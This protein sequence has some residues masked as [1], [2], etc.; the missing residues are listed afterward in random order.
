MPNKFES[1]AGWAP[2]GSQFQS[3]G[4]AGN[5]VGGVLFG[6]LLTPIGIAFAAKGGADIRYWVIVGAVTDRWTAA[7]EIIG[8]SLILLLVVV[9]AAFSP[10]G[11]AV[12]GLVWGI[13]PGIL[14]LLFPDETFALIANLTF[15]NSEMQVALHAWVTYGFALVSGFMLLGAGIVGTLRRR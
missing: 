3:R 13:L 10:I 11:T 14:H 2:P 1:P 6:L 9:A 8:G 7:L 4:I 5:T 12:A 15:L